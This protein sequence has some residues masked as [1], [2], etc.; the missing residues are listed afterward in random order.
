MA[1]P[2]KKI[3]PGLLEFKT[4]IGGNHAFFRDI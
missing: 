1:T 2:E 3:L 4:Q